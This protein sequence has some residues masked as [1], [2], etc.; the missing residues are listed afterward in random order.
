VYVSAVQLITRQALTMVS[1]IAAWSARSAFDATRFRRLYGDV[2][3]R[4]P[5]DEVHHVEDNV[6]P[7]GIVL[8]QFPSQPLE[9]RQ[10]VVPRDA[11]LESISNHRT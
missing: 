10:D 11:G 4:P 5:L 9:I 7:L 1:P 3:T 2:R 6:F 8:P